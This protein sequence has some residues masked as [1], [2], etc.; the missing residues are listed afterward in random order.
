MPV[1]MPKK[2]AAISL[3]M[4]A[5]VLMLAHAVIPHHHHENHVCFE[6]QSCSHDQAHN[7]HS[8]A[9]RYPENQDGECCLLAN[10]QLFNHS[11]GREGLEC[12][13]CEMGR[14][15]FRP[16]VSATYDTPWAPLL[17]ERPFRQ[18][19]LDTPDRKPCYAGFASALRAPPL[20]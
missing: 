5:S 9:D 8:E 10:L 20:A 11:V 17:G 1:G 3:I 13:C 6:Q 16:D 7:G 14:E 15:Q 12:P 4:L 2:F 18:T 19:P